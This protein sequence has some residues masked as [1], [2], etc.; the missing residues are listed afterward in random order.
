MTAYWPT[1]VVMRYLT[2]PQKAEL[3]NPTKRGISWTTMQAC[4]RATSKLP[5]DTALTAIYSEGIGTRRVYLQ[6]P[7]YEQ[8]MALERGGFMEVWD[9]FGFIM[10]ALH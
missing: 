9:D 4:H 2:A 3:I 7:S 8:W 1:S 5:A 10:D 6:F